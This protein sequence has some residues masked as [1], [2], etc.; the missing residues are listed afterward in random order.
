MSPLVLKYSVPLSLGQT[1]LMELGVLMAGASDAVLDSI[2]NPV[3][4]DDPVDI[5]VAIVLAADE[6]P[7]SI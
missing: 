7:D 6:D 4:I 5:V 3:F 1:G 2:K